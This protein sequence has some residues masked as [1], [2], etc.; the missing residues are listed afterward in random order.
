MSR[1]IDSAVQVPGT[2]DDFCQLVCQQ[3]AVSLCS[4]EGFERHE[5]ED[6]QQ[7][8]LLG[9]WKAIP[10]F[11]PATA[12]WSAWVR[13]VVRMLTQKLTR[14]RRRSK[15]MPDNEL[16][17]HGQEMVESD[18]G[19]LVP[20]SEELLDDST[21]FNSEGLTAHELALDVAAVLEWLPPELRELAEL[22][23]TE[24]VVAIA[25]KRGVARCHVRDQVEELRAIFLSRGFEGNF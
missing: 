1:K 3:R 22:L 21:R 10:S 7:E 24:S 19:Y 15:R 20:L 13:T 25:E 17:S 6:L 2:L 5:R 18:D 8:L 12:P 9:L 16:I 14:D 23:K 11:D 4:Q